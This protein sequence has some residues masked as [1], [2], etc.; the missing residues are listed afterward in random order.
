MNSG[1]GSPAYEETVPFGR[2]CLT[3]RI[4]VQ[5]QSI[6]FESQQIIHSI[7]QVHGMEM[8]LFVKNRDNDIGTLLRDSNQWKSNSI[9]FQDVCQYWSPC[10]DVLLDTRILVTIY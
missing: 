6:V 1:G 5:I 9:F 8:Y 2:A 3:I 7:A 10:N 4:L